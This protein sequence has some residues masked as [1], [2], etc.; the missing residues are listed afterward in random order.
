MMSSD[1]FSLR[2]FDY[3]Q[4]FDEELFQSVLRDNSNHRFPVFIGTVKAEPNRLHELWLR[5]TVSVES[6]GGNG[7]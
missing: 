2:P 1:T 6:N 7:Q 3:D 5:A 4:F